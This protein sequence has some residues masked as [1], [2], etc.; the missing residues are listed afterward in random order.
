MKKWFAFGQVSLRQLCTV[1]L[2]AGLILLAVSAIGTGISVYASNT[3]FTMVQ[4]G[5]WYTGVEVNNLPLGIA[6]G[7]LVFVVGGILWR[8]C[9]EAVFIVLRYFQNNTGKKDE[10]AEDS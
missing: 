9:C 8:I 4:Q 6:A 10:P 3:Y 5:E 1:L 2:A 7:L